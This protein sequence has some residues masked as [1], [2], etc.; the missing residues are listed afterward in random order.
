MIEKMTQ[1]A[2]PYADAFSVAC[3]E[4]GI[5][6][7]L[8]I[9][10][11]AAQCAHESG[12][13]RAVVENLNYSATA[14]RKTWPSRF[15]SREAEH[16]ERQQPMIANRVYADR[17]GNGPEE[18]GDGWKFRGRGLIQLTGKN[19]Y[20]RL[21]QALFKD[22]RLL[23]KPEWLETP[24]GA[25]RSAAHFWASDPR[26]TT[27]ALADNLAAVSGIVNTGSPVKEAH[28]MDMRRSWLRIAKL[29]FGV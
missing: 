25:C 29:S 21:S 23:E 28:G 11:F 16:Y 20:R 7:P 8:V 22:D 3:K 17:M 1:S 24:E 13:F 18:S 5:T 19:N 15:T 2:K 6:S 26:L 27:F 9:A 10:H 4:F 14:L 12:S